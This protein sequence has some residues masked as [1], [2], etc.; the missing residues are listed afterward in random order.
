MPR[1]LT[2]WLATVMLVVGA[3]TSNI[4][5]A[6]VVMSFSDDDDPTYPIGVA[7][8]DDDVPPAMPSASDQQYYA[9]KDEGC[10]VCC[11]DCYVPRN[12][13]SADYLMWWTKGNQL[14]PL[15]T[16]SPPGALGVLPGANILFGNAQIDN[17]QRN[18]LR[19]TYG[20]WADP[21]GTVGWQLTYFSVFDDD[22]TGDYA[23]GTGVP[24]T[25]T[26]ILARP[27]FN[28][29][30]NAP[31][32]LIVSAPAIADGNIAIN[33]SSEMHSVSWMMRQHFRSGSKGRVDLVGGYRY[34]RYREGL[35]IN[36]NSQILPGNLNFPVGTTFAFNDTFVA[37]NDFHGGDMGFVAEFWHA[38]WTLEVLA[39][40]ALGNI[41]RTANIS[42]STTTD[43]PP[44]GGAVTTNGGLLALPTNIGNRTSNDFAALPEF[45]LNLKFEATRNLT[46]NLGYT[47]LMLND[48]VRTGELIDPRVNPTQ[49][50]GGALAGAAFPTSLFGANQTDFWA[51]GLNFGL[52]YNF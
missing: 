36:T 31:D 10:F 12:W 2:R 24:L 21:D 45:G 25:G 22:H 40:V 20:H 23:N 33:S 17:D 39:K 29:N 7:S 52:T 26:P 32:S 6:Q 42:G 41:H 30:L 28:V 48:V 35:T 27:I 49:L 16:T 8:E 3:M 9:P 14:P 44:A 1:S 34:F 47:L 50:S 37:E 51:Q 46:L 43:T 4:G 15:V 18:G 5:R 13:V 19:L 11:D 38:G